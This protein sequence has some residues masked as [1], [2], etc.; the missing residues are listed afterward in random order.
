METFENIPRSQ[1]YYPTQKQY[2]PK[3]PSSSRARVHSP[4]G[5][6]SSLYGHPAA[7]RFSLV[8]TA[9]EIASAAAPRRNSV[10]QST[11][12]PHIPVSES[13]QPNEI[14]TEDTPLLHDGDGHNHK[15]DNHTQG[16]MN[17]RAL[18]LHVDRGW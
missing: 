7:T 2:I 10:S 4:T 13:P 15:H 5:S 16:S 6:F 1:L 9:N 3:S 17:M 14:L 18:V 8:Q 12:A 11:A